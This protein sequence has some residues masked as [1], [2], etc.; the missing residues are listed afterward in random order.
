[1]DVISKYDEISALENPKERELRLGELC[2][3]VYSETGEAECKSTSALSVGWREKMQT[4]CANTANIYLEALYRSSK[5]GNSSPVEEEL[6]R[7]VSSCYYNIGFYSKYLN[8]EG[9]ITAN[10][11]EIREAVTHC[12]KLGSHTC[13]RLCGNQA[14]YSSCMDLSAQ[15]VQPLCWRGVGSSLMAVG[16]G[17][18]CDEYSRYDHLQECLALCSGNTCTRSAWEHCA[19]GFLSTDFILNLGVLF[20]RKPE[21]G[22][23]LCS[24][25]QDI[26]LIGWCNRKFHSF[27]TTDS[28]RYPQIG[29]HELEHNLLQNGTKPR[30]P[31]GKRSK[32]RRCLE[33]GDSHS[34]QCDNGMQ[35]KIEPSQLS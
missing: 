31:T 2:D 32:V 33:D 17:E 30:M 19:E 10:Y 12:S 14:C 21:I 11:K 13:G 29:T 23:A 9:N 24:L 8:E 15:A 7:M 18:E 16:D 35:I 25:L 28:S 1:M 26:F 27:M 20:L 34:C 4:F 5:E 22:T 3:L 6:K